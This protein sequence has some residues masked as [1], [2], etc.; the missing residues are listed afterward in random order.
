MAA[1][2]DNVISGLVQAGAPAE[3]IEQAKQNQQVVHDDFEVYP[4]NWAALQFFLAVSTQW[5]VV[6]GRAGFVYIGF[7][8]ACLEAEMNMRQVKLAAREELLN[9]VNMMEHAALA[10]LNKAKK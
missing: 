5:N 3:V 4:E 1:I 2:D 8:H 10:V 6:A 7:N 9:S